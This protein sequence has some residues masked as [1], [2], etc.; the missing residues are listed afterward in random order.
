MSPIWVRALLG[1]ETVHTYCNSKQKK[2]TFI[3]RQRARFETEHCHVTEMGY[4][5]TWK[6]TDETTGRASWS[7]RLVPLMVMGGKEQV[8]G[9][10]A[11]RPGQTSQSTQVFGPV[12]RIRTFL[13]LFSRC[14]VKIS[15]FCL[16]HILVHILT[17]YFLNF[18]NFNLIPN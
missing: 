17:L 13:C 15:F 9:L 1:M 2:Y 12:L 16:S 3:S 8:G 4:G 18:F 10:L 14:S 5:L 11:V 7:A 6:T